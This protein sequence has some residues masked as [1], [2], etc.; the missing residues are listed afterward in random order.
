MEWPI[1]AF[2]FAL[3]G[4]FYQWIDS[5]TSQLLLLFNWRTEGIV[6]L[7]DK[8]SLFDSGRSTMG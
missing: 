1:E 3:E 4:A 2:G 7:L 6:T 5:I 8:L